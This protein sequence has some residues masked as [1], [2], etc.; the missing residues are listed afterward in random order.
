ME[1]PATRRWRPKRNRPLPVHPRDPARAVQSAHR[2]SP[3]SQEAGATRDSRQTVHLPP[4]QTKRT[5][6]KNPYSR[7]KRSSHPMMEATAT[8]Q[9]PGEK[10]TARKAVPPEVTVKGAEPAGPEEARMRHRKRTLPR[11]RWKRNPSSLKPQR[12][13][14]VGP[15]WPMSPRPW[16]LPEMSPRP[17]PW[18]LP[19]TSPRP[20]P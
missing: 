3:D 18:R 2:A 10:A 4:R 14:A 19:E 11:N 5:R 1:T 6:R 13:P 8:R 20:K 15:R 7:M 17:R 16:R 12:N 9:R